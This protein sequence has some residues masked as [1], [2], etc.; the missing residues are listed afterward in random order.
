MRA[1]CAQLAWPARGPRR[2]ALPCRS[3]VPI[4][5]C[6]CAVATAQPASCRGVQRTDGS[7]D[8]NRQLRVLYDDGNFVAFDKPPDVPMSGAPPAGS[9]AGTILMAAAARPR[10]SMES[11]A[12]AAFGRRLWHVHQLDYSTSGVLLYAT[13]ADAAAA[14]GVAFQQRLVTKTYVALVRG[15]IRSVP[16]GGEPLLRASDGGLRGGTA[17]EASKAGAAHAKRRQLVHELARPRHPSVFYSLLVRRARHEMAAA[18][19][20]AP[21]HAAAAVATSGADAHA[22]ARDSVAAEASVRQALARHSWGEAKR[23]LQCAGSAGGLSP[24]AISEGGLSPLA[25]S[26]GG[27]SPLAVAPGDADAVVQGQLDPALVLAAMPWATLATLPWPQC[28]QHLVQLCYQAAAADVQRYRRSR[29]AALSAGAAGHYATQRSDAPSAAHG[30][31][32]TRVPFVPFRLTW[33]IAEDQGA[34]H[35]MA[36]GTSDRPGKVSANR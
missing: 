9:D 8:V 19:A 3:D 15:H 7:V 32:S 17:G 11:L 2:G 12:T 31:G 13:S 30:A 35:R 27:L 10:E 34:A 28:V 20:L 29:D 33:Q 24:L 25:V 5:R 22:A 6:L 26:A 14:A 1:L 23:A 18:A 36:T 16:C 4:A 21:H